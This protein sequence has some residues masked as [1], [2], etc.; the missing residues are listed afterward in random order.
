MAESLDSPRRSADLE[1]A[2]RVAVLESAGTLKPLSIG[3]RLEAGLRLN[4]AAVEF[5]N[6]LVLR[7]Q[8]D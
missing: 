7:P 2:N 1:R 8:D 6:S 4:H 5:A 3:D